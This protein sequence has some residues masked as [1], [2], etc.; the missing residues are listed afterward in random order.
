[1]NVDASSWTSN[2]Q[3]YNYRMSVIKNGITKNWLKQARSCK[4]EL[5]ACPMW[6][7]TGRLDCKLRIL[8]KYCKDTCNVCRAEGPPVDCKVTKF[9]CC[10]DKKTVAKDKYQKG[11]P[12]CKDRYV[13]ECKAFV[14]QCGRDDIRKICPQ[15][16]GVKCKTCDDDIYQKHICPLYKQ[17]K[18]C[19]RSPELMSKYCPRTC[20]F[21]PSQLS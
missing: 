19:N 13:T 15:T 14:K 7:R 4:D 8:K 11:C 6:K 1:M 16:C 2:E 20:G 18:F 21:C 17:Y 10:W 12:A 5:K 3:R 9:G